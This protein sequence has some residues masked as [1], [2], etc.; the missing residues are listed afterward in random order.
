MTIC[1]TL[2]KYMRLKFWHVY[3]MVDKSDWIYLERFYWELR[4]HE[5][6]DSHKIIDET[7]MNEYSI[8]YKMVYE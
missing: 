3:T 8:K 2:G 1:L 5:F 4:A 7:Y 6:I